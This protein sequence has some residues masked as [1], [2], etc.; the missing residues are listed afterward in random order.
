[1]RFVTRGAK[2]AGRTVPPERV[3][4]FVRFAVSKRYG[5]ERQNV[6][7][8]REGAVVVCLTLPRPH[9][10]FCGGSK[11]AKGCDLC[12]QARRLYEREASEV[13][14]K[15]LEERDAEFKSYYSDPEDPF[16]MEDLFLLLIS[17]S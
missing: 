11:V 1:M 6:R 14:Y 8:D 10:C 5:K 13:V 7:V 3:A 4:R 15:E 12:V 9:G 16:A 17:F 2:I